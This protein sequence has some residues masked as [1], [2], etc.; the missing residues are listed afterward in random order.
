MAEGTEKLINLNAISG[1]ILPPGVD[2]GDTLAWNGVTW[3]P[4]ILSYLHSQQ[5]VSSDGQTQ[6][7]VTDF[8]VTDHYLILYDDVP[9]ARKSRSGQTIQLSFPVEDGHKL[10]VFN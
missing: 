5:F 4:R 2:I 6:V 3:E 7:I 9:Q 1:G 10:E 8:P